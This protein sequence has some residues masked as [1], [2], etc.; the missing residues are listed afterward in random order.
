[1]VIL[2][3]SISHSDKVENIRKPSPQLQKHNR[4]KLRLNRE[5]GTEILKTQEKLVTA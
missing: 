5:Q 3:F 2:A 1:M 4:Q